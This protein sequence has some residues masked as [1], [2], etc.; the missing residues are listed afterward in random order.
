MDAV[1]VGGNVRLYGWYD[2][3]NE[4][5]A[6]TTTAAAEGR[7]GDTEAEILEDPLQFSYCAFPPLSVALLYCESFFS[8][9]RLR[10]LN[11]LLFLM[12]NVDEHCVNAVEC[13]GDV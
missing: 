2:D 1:N 5:T 3:L 6:A 13:L 4:H 8:R 11:T 12:K 10:Y 7:E 9:S